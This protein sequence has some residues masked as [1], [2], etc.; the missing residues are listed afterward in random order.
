MLNIR[1][2]A[3]T[4]LR[5]SKEK[6]RDGVIEEAVRRA[7]GLKNEENIIDAVCSAFSA[8]RISINPNWDGSIG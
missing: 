3:E 4:V 7:S 8:Y 6:F 2:I 1:E 5:N